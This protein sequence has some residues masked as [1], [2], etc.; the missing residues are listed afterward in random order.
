MGNAR[1][2]PARQGSSR[3]SSFGESALGSSRHRAAS[4]S[5]N[6]WATLV[7]AT[8][9]SASPSRFDAQRFVK[10]THV[11]VGQSRHVWIRLV[12]VRLGR[13]GQS[14]QRS[15]RLVSVSAV[16]V[17][18]GS[19]GRCSFRLRSAWH[20]QVRQSRR[21]SAA[22]GSACSGRAVRVSQCIAVRVAA[23]SVSAVCGTAVWSRQRLF[24]QGMLSFGSQRTARRC[25]SASVVA[26]CDLSR[27]SG[28]V[29]IRRCSA[30]RAPVSSRSGAAGQS[31]RVEASLR[32]VWYVGAVQVRRVSAGSDFVGQCPVGHG[33]RGQ[34]GH[35]WSRSRLAWFGSH[36]LV[37]YRW[38][39]LVMLGLD[40]VR[41]G[42]PGWV[43]RGSST[44]CTA[45]HVSVGPSG[46]RLAWLGPF[47]HG[48]PSWRR[49]ACS[50]SA[51][52]RA[53]VKAPHRAA[54]CVSV[55]FVSASH[56]S[57]GIASPVAAPSGQF[58]FGSASS[59]QGRR[60]LF[61][62]GPLWCFI[63]W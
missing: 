1:L 56:D 31:C 41:H 36:G 13:Q 5:G 43:R 14:G 3:Q 62:R 44:Q 52:L 12:S 26:G 32:G 61:R 51:R 20:G 50:G 60:G 46:R 21:G 17:R 29:Q 16:R 11:W 33:R 30:R 34:A 54:S 49:L 35:G 28:Q 48:S 10:A 38:S 19:A 63:A 47:R 57:L 45:T 22:P 58:W 27:Q 25:W 40:V 8:R 23:T 7:Q 55:R 53:A 18:L 59:R 42:S 24:S 4:Q 6:R 2:V 9:R 39:W 15:S 37:R